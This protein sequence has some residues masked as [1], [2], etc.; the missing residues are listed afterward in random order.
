MS[1]AMSAKQHDEKLASKLAAS[2]TTE[3]TGEPTPGPEAVPNPPKAAASN[4]NGHS[5]GNGNGHYP[6]RAERLSFIHDQIEKGGIR[7]DLTKKRNGPGSTA[8]KPDYATEVLQ[9]DDLH[10]GV[11]KSIVFTREARKEAPE[12]MKGFK[13]PVVG[14]LIEVVLRRLRAAGAE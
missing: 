6:T 1:K 5:N 11:L 4:G 10:K 14:E 7:L 13:G 9:M 8:W 12:G 2:T 3:A